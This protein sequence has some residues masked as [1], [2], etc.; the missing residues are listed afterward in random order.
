ML[1]LMQ[2]ICEAFDNDPSSPSLVV[3]WLPDLKQWYFSFVRYDEP[4]GQ[5]K[6][7]VHRVLD[8]DFSKGM[9]C[10]LGLIKGEVEEMKR[11]RGRPVL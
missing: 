3:S 11:V 7:V 1:E 5:G 9:E 4:Y 10:I 8:A 2:Q 6:R